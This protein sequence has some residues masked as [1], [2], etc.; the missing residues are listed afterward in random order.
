[1][2]VE[3]K[4]DHLALFFA[5]D[6]VVMVLHGDEAGKVVG[7]LEVEHLLEL[8]SV[9]AGSA[10]IESFTRLDDIVEGFAGLF[11]G[12]EGIEAM[13]LV[14]VNVVDAEALEGAVDGGHDVLAGEAAIVGAVGHGLKDLGGDDEFFAAGLELAEELAGDTFALADGVHVGGVE[15]VDAG[16]DGA[17]DEGAGFVFFEDPLAPLFGAVG[18]HA[19]AERGRC[20]CRWDRD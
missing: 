10:E 1:M 2:L 13:D 6:E 9:H 20:G 19:Q 16:F 14:E 8:P 3:A 18:H 4:R 5:V 7:L 15:E 11:D 12:G 17:L